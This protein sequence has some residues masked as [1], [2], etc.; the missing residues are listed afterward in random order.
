MADFRKQPDLSPPPDAEKAIRAAIDAYNGGRHGARARARNLGLILLVPFVPLSAAALWY[1][2]A[3]H[4]SDPKLFGI[5]LAASVFGGIQLWQLAHR[6]ARSFSDG[7]RAAMMPGLFGF[8]D[9]FGFRADA[10]PLSMAELPERLLFGVH[11]VSHGDVITG[12]YEGMAFEIAESHYLKPAGK[13]SDKTVFRGIIFH[14]QTKTPFPG[15]LVV[16]RPAGKLMRALFG[17]AKQGLRELKCANKQLAEDHV[18]LTDNYNPA[19]RLV[20]GPLTPF[21]MWLKQNW[22]DGVGHVVLKG[23]EIFLLIPS[24]KDHFELPDLSQQLD[25]DRHIRPMTQQLWRILTSGR[26]LRDMLG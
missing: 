9:Q 7:A 24:S 13:H 8:I 18:F 22:P 5:V 1:V 19:Q 10:P 21:L 11:T 17:D 23:G 25:Y 3:Y 20:D 4:G 14:C 6:K 16:S 12:Y 15:L 26:L 2:A